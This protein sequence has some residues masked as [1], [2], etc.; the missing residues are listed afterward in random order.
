[1]DLT[2]TILAVRDVGRSARF[3]ADA[4]GWSIAVEVPV[5]VQFTL[6]DGRSLGVYERNSFGANT[7]EV[8]ELPP[9]GALTGTE[10]Y[11]RTKDLGAATARLEAA[12]ARLLSSARERDWGDTVAYYADP[13]GHVLAV[14]A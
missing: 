2:L 12:G 14:S 10:L 1:M 9:V 7:G 3:Y 11:F 5:Y 6:P 8:P 13:D 4:F